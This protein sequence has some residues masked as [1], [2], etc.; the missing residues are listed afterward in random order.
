[1]TAGDE[2]AEEPAL[3]LRPVDLGNYFRI[4]RLAVNEAQVG[5]LGGTT[6][7]PN[8]FALAEAA[9]VPCFT[10]RAIYHRDEPV[11]LIVWGPYHEG[12]RFQEPPV[13]GTWMLD[14]V[15]IA[16]E[17]QGRG[18]GTK[19]IAMALEEIGNQAG[20]RRIVLAYDHNN[21]GV[22]PLYARFGFRPCGADHEG[23]PM[24]ELLTT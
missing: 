8:E 20:C 10:P 18:F 2:E 19:A 7:Y 5:F 12:Y 1:M 6:V 23:S 14:H 3:T 4:M 13:V 11:G 24:M 16:R 22:A 17:H 15:M 9:Y 21:P